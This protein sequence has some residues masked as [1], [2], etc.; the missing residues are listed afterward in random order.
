M[1]IASGVLARE[2]YVNKAMLHFLPP[3]VP[4]QKTVPFHL[5]NNPHK[6]LTPH[7]FIP[8]ATASPQH[9]GWW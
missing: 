9:H 4:K 8:H 6:Y 5:F 2:P 1:R 3:N 7:L